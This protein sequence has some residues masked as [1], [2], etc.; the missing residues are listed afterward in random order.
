MLGLSF[1]AL[2]FG[3]FGAPIVGVDGSYFLTLT[4]NELVRSVSKVK[5]PL[6]CWWVVHPVPELCRRGRW[7]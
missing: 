4:Q 3:V 7:Q 1:F 5:L 6:R 2:F